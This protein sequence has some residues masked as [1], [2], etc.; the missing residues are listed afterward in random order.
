MRHYQNVGERLLKRY[1]GGSGYDR[2]LIACHDELRSEI[3]PHLHT[4]L[5]E[6]LL[7]YCTLDVATATLDEVR[8]Q[9]SRLLRP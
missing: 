9:A 4:Y 7:G 8:A 2:L 6:I 5:R 1:A 3:E